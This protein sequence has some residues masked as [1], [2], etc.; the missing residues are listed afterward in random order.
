MFA[1]SHRW[2][3]INRQVEYFVGRIGRRM[4]RW[5]QRRSNY[6]RH[7][8]SE[9][10]I[11]FPQADQMQNAIEQHVLDMVAMFGL[12]GHSGSSAAYART[13]IDKA[14]RFEPFS[15]LTGDE[16]EW[17]EVF[18]SDGTRQ[19][20]RCS[21]VFRRFDGTAYDINGRIFEDP[22]GSRWSG[23]TSR[24]EVTF[25]YTPSTEIVMVDREGNSV[26]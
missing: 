26:A 19:N 5:S 25:P 13:Y 1:K 11:A 7:A 10:R 18:S 8:E 23:F 9:W 16:S 21:H 20:R 6:I 22:N 4:V 17:G 2:H 15:P 24:V 3:R 12:E 14:L